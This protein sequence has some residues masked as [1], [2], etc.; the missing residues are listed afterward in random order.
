MTLELTPQQQ[1]ALD[2]AHGEPVPL[3][4]PRT[5]AAYVLVPAAEYESLREAAEDERVQKAVRATALRNAVRRGE[6]EP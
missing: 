1:Q 3:I 5:K 4:D 6:E 2:G